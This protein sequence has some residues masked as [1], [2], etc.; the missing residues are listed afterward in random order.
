MLNSTQAQVNLCPPTMTTMVTGATKTIAQILMVHPRW[1][2]QVVLTVT[3][4][5]IQIK[6]SAG[7]RVLMTFAPT[8]LTMNNV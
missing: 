2:C 8:V 6:V 4:M 1:D 3:E 5:D 7:R